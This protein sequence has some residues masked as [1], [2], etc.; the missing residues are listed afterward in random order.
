M[1]EG[2]FFYALVDITTF[3]GIPALLLIISSRVVVGFAAGMLVA[4]HCSN[5]CVILCNYF[6]P[7]VFAECAHACEFSL[8]SKI[9]R[10]L[11]IS[12]SLRICYIHPQRKNIVRCVTS[13]NVHY[14]F[15]KFRLLANIEFLVA[16][17]Y[18]LGP[19]LGALFSFV[20]IHICSVNINDLTSPGYFSGTRKL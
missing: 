13:V 15:I 3:T 20:N 19:A 7:A 12:A 11:G 18:I 2:Y 8:Q 9:F 1:F 17:S 14:L 6:F 16:V 4:K 10:K 5:A